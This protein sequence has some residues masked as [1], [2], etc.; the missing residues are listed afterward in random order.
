MSDVTPLIINMAR[1]GAS[2]RDAA[3][4][5]NATHEA[6]GMNL[7]ENPDKIVT[8]SKI[9]AAKTRYLTQLAGEAVEPTQAIFFDGKRFATLHNEEVEDV[10][11]H[12]YTNVDEH[13]VIADAMRQSYLGEISV[14]KGTG[15]VI[16][17]GIADFIEKKNGLNLEDVTILGC[18]STNVNVGKHGG[19]I[20][21]IEQKTG[22][23]FHRFICLLHL[24]ELLLRHF[25]AYYVG[26]TSG[27]RSFTIPFS[28]MRSSKS[29][30]GKS[31]Y[32]E[33]NLRRSAGPI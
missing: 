7:S 16:G 23:A 6:D 32:I 28:S 22:R 27:P 12:N 1:R 14:D 21:H 24:I 18:D 2:E 11:Q 15:E 17:D 13:F 8:K 33:P 10:F 20:A 3:S 29:S 25:V 5:A 4:W 26:D 30:W 31:S 19:V 9:H